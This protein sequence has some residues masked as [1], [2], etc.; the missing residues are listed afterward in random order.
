MMA[1]PGVITHAASGITNNSSIL[2]GEISSMGVA[3]EVEAFF[4]YRK[5]GTSSWYG[6]PSQIFSAPTLYSIDT[7]TFTTLDGSSEYEFFAI[8][9]FDYQGTTYQ[10]TGNILTFT[11]LEGFIHP[12]VATLD[13]TAVEETS[14]TLNGEIT[15]MGTCAEIQARFAY[16]KATD[17]LYTLTSQQTLTAVGAYSLTVTGLDPD[18][19]YQFFARIEYVD[20]ESQGWYS[21]GSVKSFTTTPPYQYAHG[22]GTENDPYQIWTPDDLNAVRDYL[23]AW[24]IQKANINV[25]TD[26][27]TWM[28]ISTFTGNYDGGNFLIEGLD[29]D[30]VI[31][32]NKELAGL[33]GH[34]N[35]GILKNIRVDGNFYGAK[36]VGALA[37]VATLSNIDNCHS[38][39]NVTG[40]EYVGGLVGRV[41][42][43]TV[44]NSGSACTVIGEHVDDAYISIVYFGG[45]GNIYEAECESRLVGGLLGGANDSGS[46]WS[47]IDSCYATGSVK[48]GDSAAELE[49]F[50]GA[51]VGGFVGQ[52]FTST[53][54]KCYANGDVKGSFG[55]GGFGG[56]A[57]RVQISDCYARGTVTPHRDVDLYLHIEGQPS[58][59]L[60]R[61]LAGFMGRFQEPESPPADPYYI[62]HAYCT[63]FVHTMTSDANQSGGF[64]YEPGASVTYENNYYDKET[65]Q[66]TDTILATPKTT[67]EM[68][69]PYSDPEN[70]YINW[71][72]YGEDPD[73]VWAHDKG[74][75]E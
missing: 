47:N 51:Y 17:E 19:D 42:G 31:N 56:M 61:A 3:T 75:Q 1:A 73:P 30:V 54:N 16:K 72:F 4:A 70:V 28:P 45:Y 68:V 66:Q 23:S 38:S 20:D 50:Y 10:S 14:T 34:V 49:N 52:I 6:T 65:A 9:Y 36:Y 63:G 58:M 22:S 26:Y 41:Q 53:V 29:V 44:I 62:H 55:V 2:N 12:S 39:G 69:Y 59:R 24:F 64:T 13:A 71:A 15:D 8:V 7:S 5:A 40:Q 48:C 67:A 46:T 11:T 37:G 33:F 25:S 35:G 60:L 32:W 43:T 27:P 74:G 57:E 21:H 18:T